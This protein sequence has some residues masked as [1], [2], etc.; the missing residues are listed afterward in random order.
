MLEVWVVA[1]PHCQGYNTIIRY[2]TMQP[3]EA[4]E[5][6]GIANGIGMG[7]ELQNTGETILYAIP[8]AASITR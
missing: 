5:L 4:Y 7:H 3:N 2:H 8:I 6:Y 1:N